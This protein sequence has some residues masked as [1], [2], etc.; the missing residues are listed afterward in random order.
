MG[1]WTH[2]M[3]M[4]KCPHSLGN[5]KAMI[6]LFSFPPLMLQKQ[7]RRKMASGSLRHSFINVSLQWPSSTKLRYFM[8]R[9]H[10]QIWD[11]R[12]SSANWFCDQQLIQNSNNCFPKKGPSLIFNVDLFP[13][14]RQTLTPGSFCIFCI[15]MSPHSDTTTTNHILS[16][17]LQS[18]GDYY[19][20]DVCAAL[21]SD[22]CH[23]KCV[24]RV[25]KA[26]GKCCE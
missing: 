17:V 25:K 7:K 3:P 11:H 2:S 18:W 21:G 12:K 22:G 1:V 5:S 26:G 20:L 10:H 6:S 9:I 23:A 15:F 16:H 19:V 24:W 13:L 8:I 4:W 14:S